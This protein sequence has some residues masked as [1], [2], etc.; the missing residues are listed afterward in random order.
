[1][2]GKEAII[3]K[4]LDDAKLEADNIVKQANDYAKQKAKQAKEESEKF[5]KETLKDKD[6][7]EKTAL[8]RAISVAELDVKKIELAAKKKLIDDCFEKAY[9]QLQK[10]DDKTTKKL[11][12]GMLMTHAENNDVVI[13]SKNDSKIIDNAFIQSIA[14]E[15]KIKLS[16]SKTF[17][18]F[19]KGVILTGGGV[20]KNLSIDIELKLLREEIETEI[21]GLIF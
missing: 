18:D 20:D 10:L 21:A 2:S 8:E 3:K 16:L 7:I 12:K 9:Q 14:K 13:I 5:K 1:M 19:E 15:K 6:L 11:V 4:I 17:G